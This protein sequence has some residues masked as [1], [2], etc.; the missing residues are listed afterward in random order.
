M[1]YIIHHLQ[2]ASETVY[3]YANNPFQG[4]AMD[5]ARQLREL[6]R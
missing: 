2:S 6:V 4:Q 5:T 3:V 1:I